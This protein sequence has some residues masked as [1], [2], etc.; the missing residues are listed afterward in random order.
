[1]HL[2]RERA[3]SLRDRARAVGEQQV[4]AVAE[5]EQVV[6]HALGR[7]LRIAAPTRPNR[8]QLLLLGIAQWVLQR[9][10]LDR[11][12]LL[13]EESFRHV[14]RD[15]VVMPEHCFDGDAW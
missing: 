1:W 7:N 4:E 2:L 15:D 9:R 5:G 13:V 11:R 3:L 12:G 6:D 14:R 8:V 10:G